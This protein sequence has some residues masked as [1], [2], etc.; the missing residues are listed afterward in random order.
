MP[1]LRSGL[2]ENFVRIVGK[3]MFRRVKQSIPLKKFFPLFRQKPNWIFQKLLKNCIVQ[4]AAIN[5]INL[6]FKGRIGI[7]EVLTI[8]ESVEKLIWKWAAKEK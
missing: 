5:V 3:N 7:F 4:S 2:C 1:L 8:T 6:G